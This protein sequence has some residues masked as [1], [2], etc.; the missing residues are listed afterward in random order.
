MLLRTVRIR[1]SLS[2]GALCCLP[3]AF[4]LHGNWEYAHQAHRGGHNMSERS[5]TVWH[6]ARK[7]KYKVNRPVA[8]PSVV[9]WCNFQH[10]LK[11]LWWLGVDSFPTPFVILFFP[12]TFFQVV[13]W[14]YEHKNN[15]WPGVTC[16]GCMAYL[17]LEKEYGR[18]DD[19]SMDRLPVPWNNP[20]SAVKRKRCSSNK[21]RMYF[22]VSKVLGLRSRG[23]TIQTVWTEA[24]SDSSLSPLMHLKKFSLRAA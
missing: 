9:H 15:V 2:S 5:D 1:V 21:S 19:R 13:L 14:N 24:G 22:Q 7:N 3:G 23:R 17:L 4:H 10:A 6:A 18:W 8:G 11:K 16:G 12:H 20:E